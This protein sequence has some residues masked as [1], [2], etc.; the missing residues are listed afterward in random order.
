[1]GK[2]S[3]LKTLKDLQKEYEWKFDTF[4]G[5]RQE[6]IKWI[7]ELK[8]N[9]ANVM[10]LVYENPYVLRYI[11]GPGL[12]EEQRKDKVMKIKGRNKY[13]VAYFFIDIINY[14]FNITEE[15]VSNAKR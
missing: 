5:L 1:M 3:R 12:T 9:P 10:N 6:A 4:N 11:S 15:E 14:F 13:E 7:K 2:V 8:R